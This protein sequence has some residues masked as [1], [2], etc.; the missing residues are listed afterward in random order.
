[1]KSASIP[2][3]VASWVS[4][5]YLLLFLAI[6]TFDLI[7]FATHR[8]EYPIGWEE[9]GVKYSGG[10]A[11]VVI[12]VTQAALSLGGLLLWFVYARTKRTRASAISSIASA[13]VVSMGGILIDAF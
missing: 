2:L 3:T 10:N 8:A 4:R 11:F 7:K 12:T 1:M 5:A 6:F 9:G 13:M